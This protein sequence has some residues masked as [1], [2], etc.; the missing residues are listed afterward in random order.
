MD[1][2]SLVAI[3]AVT[4]VYYVMLSSYLS[5]Q[6]S[7]FVHVLWQLLRFVLLVVFNKVTVWT[8]FCIALGGILRA[9]WAED[10]KDS[11]DWEAADGATKHTS[12]DD[13]ASE[14][15]Q[16]PKEQ[17]KRPAEVCTSYGHLVP[18]FPSFF[19]ADRQV[20]LPSDA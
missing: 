8:A 1:T 15:K 12:A 4:V 3:A 11:W 20:E 17:N 9:V 13:L 19:G 6:L 10:E 5:S 7:P 14:T 2:R 16:A 18:S